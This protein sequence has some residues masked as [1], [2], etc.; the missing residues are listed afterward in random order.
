MAPHILSCHLPSK[1]LLL[2]SQLSNNSNII[3]PIFQH[4]VE[5]CNSHAC[6]WICIIPHF[7]SFSSVIKVTEPLSPKILLFTLASKPVWEDSHFQSV[8]CYSSLKPKDCRRNLS[9][10]S[11]SFFSVG[12][13]PTRCIPVRAKLGTSSLYW[14]SAATAVATSRLRDCTSL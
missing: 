9:T 13:I 6:F 1:C 7:W 2:A 5:I 4:L 10:S 12:L 11:W 8:L 14:V 3:L